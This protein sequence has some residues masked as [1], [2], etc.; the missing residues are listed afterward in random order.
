MDKSVL[1]EHSYYWLSRSD[2][3]DTCLVYCY[4]NPDA[5]NGDQLGFGF[6]IADGGGW[7]PLWDVPGDTIIREAFPQGEE[8]GDK[9]EEAEK[10]L[11]EAAQI[12]VDVYP[13]NVDECQKS[14]HGPCRECKTIINLRALLANKTEV[15]YA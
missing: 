15:K 6:N 1:K 4:K 13:Y 14:E 8:S 10:A 12:V 3:A 2:G 9:H 5:G 11:R 7:T